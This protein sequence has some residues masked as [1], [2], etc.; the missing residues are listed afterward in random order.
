VRKLFCFT[1][2]LAVLAVP[3]F[4]QHGQF[5]E[6]IGA[7]LDKFPIMT[8]PLSVSEQARFGLS[9]KKLEKS[10]VVENHFR[11]IRHGRFV[12]ETLPAGT[13]VLA[14]KDGK[15]R[16]KADCG[17]RIVESSKCPECPQTSTAGP[18]KTTS[19]S[20]ATGAWS[21]FLNAIKKA[22]V[23]VWEALGWILGALI[24]LLLFL[25]LAALLGYAIMRALEKWQ[26]RGNHGQQVSPSPVPVQPNPVLPTQ[27][28]QPVV[29][30]AQ[31]NPAPPPPAF[32]G[33]RVIVDLGGSDFATRIQS[34]RNINRVQYDRNPDDGSATIRIFEN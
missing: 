11:N 21:R 26:N 12:L 20:N 13:L 3:V 10:V 22:W 30:S 27:P 17:N 32:P 18:V 8:K 15:L 23:G 6:P 1:L 7:E 28:N 14:D 24:P 29:P 19:E 31:P 34:G 4:S 16:Y 2:L 25:A 9:A 5:A 33:R